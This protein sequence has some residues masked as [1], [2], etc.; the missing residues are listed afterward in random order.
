MEQIVNVLEYKKNIILQ[1]A[2][3]VGKTYNTAMI[4][5]KI[6]GVDNVNFDN[7]TE[8]MKKY[9]ELRQSG[10]IEFVTFH[11]S[12]DYEDFVEGIKPEIKNGNVSYE[13]KDGIFKKICDRAKRIKNDI[14]NNE[15]ID[16]SKVQV[17][18][19]SLG[20]KNQKDIYD[21]CLENNRI[22]I[23]WGGYNDFSSCHSDEDFSKKDEKGY[24]VK[25]FKNDI[26]IGDII[27]VSYGNNYIRAIGKVTSEYFYEESE[28]DYCQHRSV[29]WL[30]KGENI[31]ISKILGNKI[32][33]QKT[34]Y[35]LHNDGSL[36]IDILQKII[37][38]K[39][40]NENSKPHVLIIDEI[41]RGNVS[42][43]FGE[44]ITL[45]ES[46]KR[47]GAKH[48]IKLTLPYSKEE[49]GIPSNLYIIGT[50]NTTD[51]SVG[52]I[53]YAVRRRFAFVT[54]PADES[55][56]DKYPKGK[57]VFEAVSKFIK[58]NNSN[59]IDF[60]DLMVGHSYF[61]ADDEQLKLKL[62][63][64]IL[65]LL[66]EYYKDGILKEKPKADEFFEILNSFTDNSEAEARHADYVARG[67]KAYQTK[68][69]N[70]EK[71]KAEARNTGYNE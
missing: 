16:F 35:K 32:L 30:Y 7:H 31:E 2:P 19:M 65:P 5:L 20:E 70:Q 52:S 39:I 44:L 71:A 24:W 51:R 14:K 57:E 64:E 41:N 36:N 11:Q 46:D 68:I 50:M 60:D 28:I 66:E 12:M 58:D 1:G 61:M 27:L 23:G 38:G 53:D 48:P 9:E 10:Q 29:E 4:A 33:S 45:L 62:K 42:K 34:L 56:L 21:Y 54:L 55:V 40:N 17:F 59:D 63:Y 47:L 22:S 3:G 26:K 18:K 15:N 49:F 69:A 43:I 8:V 67:K 25:R 6:C 13:V 37:N